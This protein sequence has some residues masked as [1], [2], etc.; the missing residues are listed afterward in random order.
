VEIDCSTCAGLVMG[1]SEQR[2]VRVKRIRVLYK[3]SYVQEWGSGCLS[4][5]R[6]QVPDIL[7]LRSAVDRQPSALCGIGISA[8][9]SQP[10]K[11]LPPTGS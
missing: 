3:G 9:I 5:S 10:N 11:V 7:A 1:G 4:E 2:E 8:S 6:T